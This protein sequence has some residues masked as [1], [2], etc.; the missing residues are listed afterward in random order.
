[1]ESINW[2]YSGTNDFNITQTNTK[3]IRFLHEGKISEKN[4]TQSYTTEIKLRAVKCSK[5][6]LTTYYLVVIYN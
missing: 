2:G 5:T 4:A 6:I 1:M 3:L